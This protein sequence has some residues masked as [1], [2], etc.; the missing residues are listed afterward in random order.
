MSEFT[1]ADALLEQLEGGFASRDNSAGAVNF[2]IT[3]RWY[4]SAIDPN[5]TSETIRNLTREQA[6]EIRR[7]YWWPMWGQIANQRL[8]TALYVTAV[9]TGPRQTITLLQ[10]ALNKLDAGLKEDG[11]MGPR[12]EAALQAAESYHDWIVDCFKYVLLTFY[13]K[14][15]ASNPAQ[16]ADDLPGWQARVKRL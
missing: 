5:A 11:I 12:T 9:N 16:Y 4:R 2:G 15:A 14:L 13:R 1:P 8:A 10:R 6:R 7:V 3:E